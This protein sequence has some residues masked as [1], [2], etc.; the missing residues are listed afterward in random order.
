M[1]FT[2]NFIGGI[3]SLFHKRQAE[4]EMDEE[5][6]G[7]IEAAAQEK[8]R[9]GMTHEQALRAARVE[10]GSTDTVKEEIRSAGWESTLETL[11]HDLRYGVRQLKRSPGFTTVAII[12][13]ALGI[14]ANT[15]IFSV[16][17]SVLLAPLPYS[18]PDR[19]VVVWE[20]NLHYGWH[21]SISY[22]NYRDWARDARSFE[23]MAAFFFQG[24]DLSSPGI[25]QHVEGK[26]ITSGFFETLGVKLA[27]GREFTSQEDQRDGAPVAIISDR[28]WRDLFGASPQALGR[29]VSLGGRD[30]TV[31]GVAPADFHFDGVADIYTPLA[32]GESAILN[33]RGAHDNMLAVARLG[34]GVNLEQAQAE[35]S[36]I[37]NRLD[38]VYPDANQGLGTAVVPLKREVVGSAGGS[39]LMLMGAV[40]LV[41]LIACANVANLLLAR[42]TARAREFA[43]RTSL[44]ASRACVVRQ[45]LTESVLLSL[46]GGGL[47]LLMAAGGTRLVLAA[48]PEN[49]SRPQGVAVNFQVLLFTLGAALLVGILFGLAPALKS[50]NPELHL[51][52]KQGGRTT[53]GGRQRTLSALVVFQTAL[54]LVLL[55]GAGLLLRT[56]R[57]LWDLNPGFDPQHL[58]TFK[59]G[60]ALSLT[61]TPSATRAAYRQLLERIRNIP[62]VEA[63]DFA[64][65]LPISG[66]TGQIPFWRDSQMPAVI[67]TAPR[68]LAFLTGPDYLRTMGIPLLQGRFYNIQDSIDSPCVVAIDSVF[69]QAYFAGKNP[70]GETLTFGFEKPF[71]G[72]C[73]IIGVVGHVKNFGM[74]DQS[75]TQAQTYY[76]LYQDPDKW[77]PLNFPDTSIII[78]T[79]LD[80]ATVMP[81]IKAVVYGVDRDQPVYDVQTMQEII[82]HSMAPQK[83]PMILLGAFA[84]LA[85]LL[86][87]VG[88]YGVIS[89]SLTQ[90]VHEIGIRMALGAQSREILWLVTGHGLRLAL[91]GVAVGGAG[92]MILTR[93]L[94]SLTDL[95]YGVGPGDPLT[96]AA[97]SL[98]LL[99]VACAACYIPARRAVRIDPMAALRNE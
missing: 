18:Q 67:Q 24:R 66:Q 46:A 72:P 19:L 99:L 92:A 79:P 98:L 11:W 56:V 59:V 64:M 85:L 76:P 93:L 27:L 77:V 71:V 88:I 34:P 50:S 55:V 37:Q 65:S 90:R 10:M 80:A 61:T 63:A 7:Y 84:G 78:R 94:P 81:A 97:V 75:P 51:S 89:F 87:S 22:L 43:I 47:G 60:V 12:T 53:A 36:A 17:D 9:T 69:A 82:S 13:L 74:A 25:S 1:S 5:L 48:A 29:S 6:R 44:G 57:R 39:L 2:G 40:G 28:L 70:V 58:I 14:G 38:Q 3:R 68:T 21:V 23:R 8:M 96:F 91:I 30:Y 15:A 16:V 42:S 54:T 33:E 26:E 83:F 52:L 95:L 45:L 35:M 62:G 73:R 4:R 86:A 32:Q 41:L 20:S 31:V 49:L